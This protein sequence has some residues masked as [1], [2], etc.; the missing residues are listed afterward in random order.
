MRTERLAT[1]LVTIA[2]LLGTGHAAA[3]QA[4]M[5]YQYDVSFDDRPI[6]TH[7][8][9]VDRSGAAKQVRSRAE[10][11][12]KL[13]FVSLYRYRHTADERWQDGCLRELVSQTDDNGRRF[14]VRIDPLDQAL[15]V[16]RRAP[17]PGN[18]LLALDCGGTFAYWDL[19]QLQRNALINSQTGSLTPVAFRH[20]GSDRIGGEPADRYRLEP[21]GLDPI[22]L[23]YRT[24]DRRWLQLETRRANGVLRYRLVGAEPLTESVAPAGASAR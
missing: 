2:L 23:W 4:S 12:V 15:R 9:E 13:L 11:Q 5:R 6:G 20:D 3:E 18:E 7:I 21:K 22:L 19:E 8:F 24:G 16:D 17:E 1:C 14:E 10:F